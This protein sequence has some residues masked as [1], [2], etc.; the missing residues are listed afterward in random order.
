[1]RQSDRGPRQNQREPEQADP[2]R[3]VTL[4]ISPENTLALC[5]AVYMAGRLNA[6]DGITAGTPEAR[7]ADAVLRILTDFDHNNAR[8]YWAMLR[9]RGA[10]GEE[11]GQAEALD[12]DGYRCI[13]CGHTGLSNGGVVAERVVA[14]GLVDPE[15]LPDLLLTDEWDAAASFFTSCGKCLEELHGKGLA[16]RCAVVPR[17]LARTGA[18]L[19]WIARVTERLLYPGGGQPPLAQGEG[20]GTPG[21]LQSR[22]VPREDAHP[23][24]R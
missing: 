21:P 2:T 11:L 3:Y 15:R 16:Y 6:W 13:R 8:A 5:R 18:G 23:P 17:L 10:R 20:L 4:K 22:E 24:D 19:D 1:M 9:R 14:P 7:Q 12:R